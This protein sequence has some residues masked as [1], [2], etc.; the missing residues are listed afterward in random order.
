MAVIR[1]DISCRKKSDLSNW[2]SSVFV[3]TLLSNS[4]APLYSYVHMK[5]PYRIAVGLNEA[6]GNIDGAG[7]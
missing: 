7:R 6:L 1:P 4:R 3:R 5:L 2:S